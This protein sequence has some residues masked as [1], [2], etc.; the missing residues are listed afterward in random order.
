VTV[1]DVAVEQNDPEVEPENVANVVFELVAPPFT[2]ATM[3]SAPEHDA[4]AVIVNVAVPVASVMA[5][6][7]WL[8]S[9]PVIVKVT[10]VPTTGSPSDK[11]TAVLVMVEPEAPQT[12]EEFTGETTMVGALDVP[13]EHPLM[14]VSLP[15]IVTVPF[16]ANAR[17]LRLPPFSVMLA[18]AMIFP[19]KVLPVSMV[20][21]E[22]TCQYTLQGDAPP[23]NA[24]VAPVAVVRVLPIWKIHTSVELPVS[25][26]V[27]FKSAEEE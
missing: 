4:G 9:G 22:P 10:V 26:R 12:I 17:P 21:E 13:E 5:V 25:V 2:V 6:P 23:A 15:L 27:P 1:G 8:E 7:L 3:E 11:T 20:A 24:T 19:A 14:M 16:L 18:N